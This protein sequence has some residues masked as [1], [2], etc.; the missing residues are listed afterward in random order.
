MINGEFIYANV[1][2]VS[3]NL[4]S[5]TSD[6]QLKAVARILYGYRYIPPHATHVKFANFELHI[7]NITGKTNMDEREETRQYLAKKLPEKW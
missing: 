6:K 1:N 4:K 2:V 7:C 3:L 5:E